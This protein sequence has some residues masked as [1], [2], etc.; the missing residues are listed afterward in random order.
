[1]NIVILSRN[2]SLYSTQSIVSAAR[3]RNHHVRVFDHMYCD[4]FI[5]NKKPRIFFNNTEIKHVDAIIPRIGS[6][7]TSI[8]ASVIRQ[9]ECMNVFT[10]MTADALLRSRDKIS[11][12]QL[13][14]ANN[15][16]VPTSALSNN[17]MAYSHLLDEI[18]PSPHIIKLVEGTHGMGV[19]LAEKKST[20][21]SVL[22]AFYSTKKKVLVQEFISEAGGADVRV[23]IVDG[24]IVGVMKRQA[25]EGEFR[26]N[27]HRGGTAKVI[28]LSEVEKKVALKAA[29]VMGLKIAGV[30][31]LQTKNGPLILEV[32]A[33]PGLE[34]IETTT[35]ID[36]AGKIIKYVE[37]NRR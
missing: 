7:V 12:L 22:E 29:E 25:V 37:K 15:I 14:A 32:N 6:T 19:I 11:C 8:G 10:T 36:I 21:E 26:S 33:S 16:G 35:G 31:M 18:G 1:M 5:D 23:F 27:L 3:R 28:S 30:D 17:Y 20:A 2:A 24:E 9:F 34:G 4:I 13:L